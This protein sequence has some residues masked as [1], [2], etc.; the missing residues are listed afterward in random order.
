MTE[1][2]IIFALNSLERKLLDKVHVDALLS[3]TQAR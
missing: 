3:E 2:S 1:E